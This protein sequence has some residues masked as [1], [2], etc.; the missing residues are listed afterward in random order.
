MKFLECLQELVFLPSV[1]N[2]RVRVTATLK[3][4]RRSWKGR[5]GSRL[6]SCTQTWLPGNALE[7]RTVAREYVSQATAW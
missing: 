6:P 7:A 5:F 1:V 4:S 2:H 3:P